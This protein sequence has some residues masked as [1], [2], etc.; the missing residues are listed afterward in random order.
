MLLSKASSRQSSDGRSEVEPGLGGCLCC[1]ART[2]GDI[3]NYEDT[4]L[5]GK[6]LARVHERLDRLE[7]ERAIAHNMYRY[8]HACDELKDPGRIA[9]FF[10][11]TAVWEGRGHFAEF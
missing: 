4:E 2:E 6:V 10:T 9:S 8:V 5:F 1:R 11:E 7:A 3:V